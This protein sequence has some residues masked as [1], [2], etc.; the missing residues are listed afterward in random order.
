MKLCSPDAFGDNHAAKWRTVIGDC[1]HTLLVLGFDIVGMGKVEIGL[2]W[3]I[4]ENGKTGS[5]WPDLVPAHM[6]NLRPVRDTPH[7]ATEEPQSIHIALGMEVC[8]QL[9]TET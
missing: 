4:G 5:R 2:G 9:H 3:N 7:F 1:R 6:R 8:Q